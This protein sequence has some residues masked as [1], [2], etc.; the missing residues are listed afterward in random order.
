[1]DAEVDWFNYFE[2]IQTV[3]PW[4]W[5]A[6]RKDLIEIVQWR[7]GISELGKYHAR[8]Y[9]APN[10]KPRQLKK[11]SDR[12]TKIRPSEEWLWSHPKYGYNSTPVPTLIQQ[13]KARLEYLRQKIKENQ[14]NIFQID[15]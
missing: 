15:K 6:I 3:C 12:L 5:S 10:Y 4:S 2:S 1:V 14:P 7:D 9:I 13:D 11:I 8:V